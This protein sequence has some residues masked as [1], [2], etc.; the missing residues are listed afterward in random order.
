MAKRG[1]RAGVRERG[2]LQGRGVVLEPGYDV[3]PRQDADQVA[4]SERMRERRWSHPLQCGCPGDYTMIGECDVDESHMHGSERARAKAV[5]MRE[6]GVWGQ[7]VRVTSCGQL[8]N[9]QRA[10]ELRHAKC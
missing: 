3:D 2:S 7:P 6:D 10:Y 9:D 4:A 1:T 5:T 8:P